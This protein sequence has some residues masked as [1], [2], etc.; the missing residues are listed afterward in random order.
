MKHLK[1]SL[2]NLRE[3]FERTVTVSQIAEPLVSFDAGKP[4]ADVRALMEQRD[5]DVVGVRT[6]GLVTGYVI[7]AELTDGNIGALRRD[8]GEGHQVRESEPLLSAI[9]LLRSQRYVFVRV[10]GQVGG[11]ITRGDLQKTPVRLWLFGLLSLLEMQMQRTLLRQ[12][13]ADAW[14]ALLSESRLASARRIFDERQR[15]NEAIDLSDCL[16][17]CDKAAILKED[18]FVL[19][20][21]ESRARLSQFLNDIERLRNALAH[22]ND[23]LNGRWPELVD[24]VTDMESVLGGLELANEGPRTAA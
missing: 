1:S 11:I 18:L 2:T 10:L 4:G 21:F 24:L 5:Y 22:A 20:K 14:T 7:R 13:P 9:T 17:L 16:Q 8:I 19:G 12:Y 3:L 15:R 6:D 23:I